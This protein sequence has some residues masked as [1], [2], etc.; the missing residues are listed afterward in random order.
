MKQMRSSSAPLFTALLSI[1]LVTLCYTKDVQDRLIVGGI[2]YR[3]VDFPYL[4]HLWLP[5]YYE[6]YCGGG[7]IGDRWILTAAHCVKNREVRVAAGIDDIKEFEEREVK[8][9]AVYIH[10]DYQ[11]I[12][13]IAT[14]GDVALIELVDKLKFDERVQPLTLPKANEERQYI[15]KGEIATVAGFGSISQR[16]AHPGHIRAV[17][18]TLYEG[19]VGCS[20]IIAFNEKSNI[21]AGSLDGIKGFC[22]GDSG[23][24]LIVKKGDKAVVLGICSYGDDCAN[25]GRAGA[26]VKVSNFLDWIHSVISKY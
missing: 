12:F 15:D 20:E 24:P 21:C 5:K 19:S 7:I 13:E 11:Q 6:G 14:R 25:P 16:G 1:S 26:L 8:V 18:L 4:V 22:Y 23:S 17:N 10:P 2:H 3:A 9:A